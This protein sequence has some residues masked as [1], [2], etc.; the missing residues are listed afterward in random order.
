VTSWHTVLHC[1]K[2]I[3]LFNLLYFIREC[4]SQNLKK[5]IIISNIIIIFF[6]T[7]SSS[8]VCSVVLVDAEVL[9]RL[10]QAASH[11]HTLG[12]CLTVSGFNSFEFVIVQKSYREKSFH[13]HKAHWAAVISVSLALSQTQAYAARPRI[14]G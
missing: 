4:T 5:N 12:F 3:Y 6:S 2:F 8:A 14:R 1:E 13:S 9:L 10:S 11:M 7:S